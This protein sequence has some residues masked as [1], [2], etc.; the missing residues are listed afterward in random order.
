MLLEPHTSGLIRPTRKLPGATVKP[1]ESVAGAVLRGV[2]EETGLTVTQIRRHIGDFDYLSPQGK[3]VRRLHFAVEV[4]ADGPIQLSAH[5]GYVWAPLD[6]DLLV[7]P[8][9]RAILD[10]YGS[11]LGS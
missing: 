7:T 6:G 9:I 5:A 2:H 4:A 1:G 8:S 11:L 3:P 10:T